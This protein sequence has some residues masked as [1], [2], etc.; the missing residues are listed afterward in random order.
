[1]ERVITRKMPIGIQTFAKIRSDG[2]VYVDKTDLVYKLAN[3][4]TMNFLGRPRR[5]GKSLLLSTLK[6]YFEGNK[7]L[8]EGLAIEKLEPSREEGGWKKYPVFHIDL[9]TGNYSLGV[10]SLKGVL[11]ELLNEIEEKFKLEYVDKDNS[12]RF[13][14]YVRQVYEKMGEKVVILIDEYDKP[15][16]LNMEEDTPEAIKRSDDMRAEL[17]AFYSVLKHQDQY[18]KFAI[19]TGVTKF[20]KVSVFSD[21]NQLS[22]LS[23]DERYASIC[24]ITQQEL[25]DNFE[26]ELKAIA[27]RNDL[28]YDEALEEMRF[29]YNGYHF[30]ESEISVYNPFSTINCLD[31]L[32]YEDYWFDTGTPTFLINEIRKGKFDISQF[33]GNIS[34]SQELI[35]DYK[36]G[37]TDP[38][39]LLYQTGYLTIIEFK[40]AIKMYKL[41]FPNEEVRTGF[42]KYLYTEFLQVPNSF[43]SKN[44]AAGFFVEDLLN[45]D[46]DSFFERLQAFYASLPYDIYDKEGASYIKENYFQYG[47]QVLFT[48]LG[49]NIQSEVRT[50]KGRADAIV[51][52]PDDIFIFE[53]KTDGTQTVDDALEQIEESGYAEKFA[54]DTRNLYKFG[55]VFDKSVRNVSEWKMV[56][57]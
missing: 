52:L 25:E 32:R 21:L 1:M 50:A 24:G 57:R 8:F 36:Q 44:L 26:P 42:N 17:K 34:I 7:E 22:D 33:A 20:S 9:N 3:S 51:Q 30:S 29:R 39:P 5:F 14:N 6:E 41:D 40:R 28:T 35:N 10:E 23:L 15:L 27:K 49:I 47:F 53:F 55:V 31:K 12:V 56:E 13:A 16:V 37:D 48:L 45:H 2:N 54:K 11:D 19:L 46:F 18:I 4:T 43:D 38:T